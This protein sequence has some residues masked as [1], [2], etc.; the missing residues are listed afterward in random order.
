MRNPN[1]A[2]IH[3]PVH[4]GLALHITRR[5][6]RTGTV[7]LHAAGK[8]LCF[9]DYQHENLRASNG[10]A[11]CLWVGTVAFDIPIDQLRKTAAFL[12]LAPS[13]ARP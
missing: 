9:V 13:E 5:T 1:F 3:V 8:T 12:D 6:P 10:P 11:P 2:Q 7:A 4:E